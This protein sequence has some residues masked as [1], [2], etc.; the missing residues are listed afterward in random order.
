VRDFGHPLGSRDFR[1][2]HSAE[3]TSQQVRTHL[4]RSLVVLLEPPVASAAL[5]QAWEGFDARLLHALH[6]DRALPMEDQPWPGRFFPAVKP[7]A[8]NYSLLG[9]AAVIAMIICFAAAIRHRPREPVPIIALLA[10]PLLLASMLMVRWMG[11]IGRFWI[12]PYALGVVI[13]VILIASYRRRAATIVCTFTA[14][15]L[16]APATFHRVQLFR[17][18][19]T[20]P[21]NL[22]ELDEPYYEPLAHMPDGSTILLAAG[23][24][25]RDYPL[26]RP[27]D[28]FANHV[29]SWG[30]SPFDAARM[31]VLLRHEN[32]THV[33]VEDDR[34][35]DFQWH[36][37]VPT[38][39]MV[40]WLAAHRDFREIP[41]PYTPH[42]RLFARRDVPDPLR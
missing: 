42:M 20:S 15:A 22:A 14:A 30:T 6:V 28:G 4:A 35:L 29:V 24:A 39:P 17:E 13:V 33:I 36:L 41:L 11:V 2:V 31:D 38:P 37:P 16:L 7:W 40:A 27:R 1:H 12:A 19:L 21:I 8:E 25:T 5:E 18:A 26:Y 9:M 10:L 23:Q 34:Q 3:L 32:P